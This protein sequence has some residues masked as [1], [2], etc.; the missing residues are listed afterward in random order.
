VTDAEPYARFLGRLE[1][2]LAGR[3][4]ATT[5]LPVELPGLSALL[6]SFA[7]AAPAP[8]DE[9]NPFAQ[10]L[11]HRTAVEAPR[12]L[13]RDLEA[14]TVV[15]DRFIELAH[16]AM[17]VLL[18]EPLFV[19]R[20]SRAGF[21]ER[22]LAFEGHCFWY[23]DIVVTRALRV[24]LPDGELARGRS[25]L[26]QPRFHPYRA[27]ASLGITNPREILDHYLD[28][29]T[30]IRGAL[31][32]RRDRT[33]VKDLFRQLASMYFISK[34]ASAA[35]AARLDDIGVF[36]ELRRRFGFAGLPA[37]LPDDLLALDD[38]RALCHAIATTGLRHVDALPPRTLRRVRERRAIQTRAYAACSLR[39]ALERGLVFSPSR[40]RVRTAP[41]VAEIARYL[42]QL[43]AALHRLA[44]GAPIADV[45]RA[46]RASDRVYSRRIRGAVG[47]LWMARRTM[48]LPRLA[49]PT[50]ELGL[51][52]RDDAGAIRRHVLELALRALD[53]S[54]A[55]AAPM[56]R[57][58]A[59]RR[60]SLDALLRE[61]A[62]LAGWSVP[63]AAIDPEA[64]RFRELHFAL[65]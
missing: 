31:Y 41:I 5:P 26:S 35:L 8:P 28:A 50:G 2:Q 65:A 9:W 38:P 15:V 36:G 30:G 21:V 16:E 59:N 58:L 52:V 62:I 6:A 45:Q 4:A 49:T 47:D 10:R 22:S 55:I 17:H 7:T 57:V 27:F 32:A 29:F 3:P 63:L 13:A 23:A 48:I 39:V 53:R 46:C 20:C 25:A 11:F 43:E 34:D 40:R 51:G 64:N 12:A 24:R 61:P 14:A 44:D 18:W 42:A 19:G 1:R 56:A 54:P 33:F 60:G 37:L